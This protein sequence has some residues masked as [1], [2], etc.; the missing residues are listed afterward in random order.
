MSFVLRVVVGVERWCADLLGA[1]SQ[2]VGR[3]RGAGF[4]FGRG[5]VPEAGMMTSQL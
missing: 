5:G 2:S 4:G 3:S 1:L